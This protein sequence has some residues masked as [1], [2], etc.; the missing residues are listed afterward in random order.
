ML[1]LV[2]GMIILAVVYLV[3]R[4][5]NL[6]SLP[7][8]VDEAIY[9]R[10]SQVMK[11]EPTLRFL[12]L[13]D[14]KQPLYMWLTIPAFK[15]FSDPLVAGRMISVAAGLGTVLGIGTLAFLLTSSVG[16]GLVAGG[17]YLL[18]P[19]A[20]FFDRMALADGV[21]SFF[22]IWSL[23]LGYA[24]V[25]WRRLDLAMI[26]GFCLGGAVLTKSPG[27]F[28]LLAL[29]LWLLAGPR[30]SVK[31]L[32][33]MILL[34]GVAGAIAFAMYNILRLG[35]NFHLIASRNLDY[36]FPLREVL[37][38]PFNPLKGN[39]ENT[40]IWLLNLLTPAAMV[41]ALSSVLEKKRTTLVL[42]LWV[43]LPL[44]GQAAIA[45]AYT[46]RYFFYVTPALVLLITLGLKQL[47]ARQ[48]I[49]AYFLLAIFVVMALRY[50]WFLSTD[51]ARAGM[52]QNMAHGYLQEWTAGW[53]QKEV[54]GYLR[55]RAKVHSVVTGTDGF[56]GTLPDGLQIY[57]ERVP[58]LTVIGV[59]VTFDKIP[60]AL[61]DSLADH[62]VY[63]VLNKSR[64]KLPVSEQERLEL[65]AEY[66]KPARPDG[67]NE[68]LQFYRLLK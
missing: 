21:L 58:N 62:E 28:F 27:W 49:V 45:K 67:T 13:S 43:L 15:V 23:V 47:V 50:D 48:K 35:P 29:P 55:E 7:V 16:W 37:E 10:W 39:G 11:S 26:A 5:I 30:V 60:T 65:I 34:Y 59:G 2:L 14:G 40:I 52:P 31:V 41:M 38:H 18:L 17:I 1:K 68:A 32:A 44:V 64:N 25:K 12:P 36:I 4:G 3:F 61:S 63:F 42:W 57:T 46:S 22:G 51:P 20:H 53:G 66:P 33:K 54:A 19:F 56:F 8:F 24:L 6:N 9:V